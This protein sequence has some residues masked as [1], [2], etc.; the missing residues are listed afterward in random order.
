MTI[1]KLTTEINAPIQ[2]VFDLNRNIDIHT[3]STAKSNETAIAGTTSGLINKGETVTWRGKHFGVYLEHKSN[4]PEMEIPHYFI[5]EM[6]E[7]K[8]KKFKHT[9]TFT[10][11]NGKTIMVDKIEYETP[12]GIFGKFF[13]LL[14]LK[15]H[16]TKFIL[17]R[18]S[19]IKEIAEKQ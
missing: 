16:L 2:L 3:K 12:F 1:I 6:V 17:E 11:K 10:E 7:G 9:H 8:F 19:F 4:I 5:D 14:L 13:D 18:N 15:N